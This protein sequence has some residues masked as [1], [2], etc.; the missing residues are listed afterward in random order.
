MSEAIVGLIIFAAEQIVQ[1]ETESKDQ[2]Q[3]T[4]ELER[5]VAEGT[6]DNGDDDQSKHT[7]EPKHF[8]NGND[9]LRKNVSGTQLKAIVNGEANPEINITKISANTP[10]QNVSGSDGLGGNGCGTQLQAETNENGHLK[11]KAIDNT[12]NEDN[13]EQTNDNRTEVK[14]N[15][16]ESN[17]ETQHKQETKLQDNGNT[18]STET[19]SSHTTHPKQELRNPN[20]SYSKGHPPLITTLPELGQV[21]GK[22]VVLKQRMQPINDHYTRS[23]TGLPKFV[24]NKSFGNPE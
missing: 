1:S 10:P 2:E 7:I 23:K 18:K 19:R 24:P 21:K 8:I 4:N 11:H 5:I 20:I 16:Q 17:N 13:N 6:D 22:V 3:L 12:G 14:Q 9:G 15:S